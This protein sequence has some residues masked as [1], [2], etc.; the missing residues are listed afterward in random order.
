[1][2]ADLALSRRLERT[3][4]RA[5]V[6]FVHARR[7]L[8]PE[9]G[10]DW[11]ECAGVF[12]AFDGVGSPITQSFGLGLFEPLSAAS[13]DSIER[14]FFDR[15]S[16][17]IHEVSP[18]A[19]AEALAL[20]C[21]RGYRPIEIS[22]VLY[23]PLDAAYF[24]AVPDN[25]RV[26]VAAAA[27]R[28]VWSDVSARAWSHEH[29]ELLDFLQQMG[30][31]VS[32]REDTLCFL[33]ELDGQPGAAGSLFIHDGVA[34]CAGSATLA[35]LRRRGLQSALLNERLRYAAGHACDAAMMVAL[36]GSDSQRNAERKGFRVAYTR[37][38]WS[39]NQ[40]L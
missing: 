14:F 20:L 25:I 17:A 39:S 31:L 18:F 29:P 15:G 22:N 10:S 26:R 3:E 37:I 36:A 12:A 40:K 32:A 38:K 19:G 23:Q 28:Q 7:W 34:L 8:F 9:R 27:E 16:Q 30:A 33:A 2:F 13:L 21:E 1:M 11:M 4:G 6:Q 5:C 35:E 24:A